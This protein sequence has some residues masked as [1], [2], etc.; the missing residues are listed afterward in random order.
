MENRSELI[1]KERILEKKYEEFK[2]I[3]DER[4]DKRMRQLKWIEYI[5]ERVINNL[6]HTIV[7]NQKLEQF[8]KKLKSM[9]GDKK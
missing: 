7:M 2:A 4:N 9:V 6:E 3:Q 5:K 8:N 1:E